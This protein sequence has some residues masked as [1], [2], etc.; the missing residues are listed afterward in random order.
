MMAA[1]HSP[2]GSSGAILS[3]IMC[4]AMNHPPGRRPREA[5]REDAKAATTTRRRAGSLAADRVPQP[6]EGYAC[7]LPAA[8]APARG[9]DS[10]T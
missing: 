7:A 4:R 1:F 6:I 5:Q 10:S 9:Q 3:Y 8:L 2:V